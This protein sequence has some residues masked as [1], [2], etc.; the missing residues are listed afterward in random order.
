MLDISKQNCNLPYL[1][2]CVSHG[3]LTNVISLSGVTCPD[4]HSLEIGLT[5]ATWNE[6]RVDVCTTKLS[7]GGLRTTME[8]HEQPGGASALENVAY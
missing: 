2:L 1:Y 7:L 6:E 4:L 8:M 5:E 3:S